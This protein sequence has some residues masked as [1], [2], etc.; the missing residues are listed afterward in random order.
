MSCHVVLGIE[1]RSSERAASALTAEL[2]P[3]QLDFWL[4]GWLVGFHMHECFACMCVCV[5]P[6]WCPGSP[7]DVFDSPETELTDGFEPPHGCW[8]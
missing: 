2:S 4:V 8:E 6:A 3:Q 7:E 5:P 1:P